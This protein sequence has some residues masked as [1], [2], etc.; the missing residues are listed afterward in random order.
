[1]VNEVA[2]ERERSANA[3]AFGA[4]GLGVGFTGLIALLTR[5]RPAYAGTPEQP[6]NV[7]VDGDVRQ[8]LAALILLGQD[9]QGQL[10]TVNENLQELISLLGGVPSPGNE[11]QLLPFKFV[12]EILQAGVPFALYELDEGKGSLI[13][14]LIDVTDPN[15][16]VLIRID[17]LLWEFKYST[18]FSEGVDRPLFP[19]AWISKYDAGTSHYALIFS[20][21]D[22]KGFKFDR[23]F[24]IN[25]RFDGVGTA[26][27]NEGR[28]VLWEAP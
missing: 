9:M 15:T 3:K 1:M 23:T 20:A 14:A 24:S 4:L 7:I 18:L 22:V 11:L 28:G 17:D 2:S 10:A 19:G 6:V 25:V 27:L 13:W 21:G 5:P 16:T 26:T 12:S 8:A